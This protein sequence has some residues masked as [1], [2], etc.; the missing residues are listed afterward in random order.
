MSWIGNRPSGVLLPFPLAVLDASYKNYGGRAL[1]ERL[2]ALRT[3]RAT[4]GTFEETFGIKRELG[5]LR[6]WKLESESEFV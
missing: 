6:S 4:V 3:L 2:V 5:A 1:Q